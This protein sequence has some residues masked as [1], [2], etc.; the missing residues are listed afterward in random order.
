MCRLWCGFQSI[1][2]S[3]SRTLPI[4][5]SDIIRS[6]TSPREGS[7]QAVPGLIRA[8]RRV[9]C[10]PVWELLGLE[11]QGWNS[12]HGS[13][14]R[15]RVV[16]RSLRVRAL[17]LIAITAL[18]KFELHGD[19]ELCKRRFSASDEA[20][21]KPHHFSIHSRSLFSKSGRADRPSSKTKESLSGPLQAECAGST[22]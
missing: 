12:G 4:S 16:A 22:A 6:K 18:G 20:I 19:L 3:I 8:Q 14:G 17:R 21:V 9:K 2:D 10:T 7:Q 5:Q 13:F 15:L 1:H 11:P